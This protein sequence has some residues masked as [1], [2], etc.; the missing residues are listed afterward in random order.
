MLATFHHATVHDGLV[1]RNHGDERGNGVFATRPLPEGTLIFSEYP[2]LGMQLGTNREAGVAVCERCFRFTGPLEAQFEGLLRGL[3][4]P[5]DLLPPQ[6]PAVGPLEEI[7]RSLPAPVP[8]PGGCALRFCSAACAGANFAE[9]HRL[10][11]CGPAA[12]SGGG[13]SSS[14][15]GSSGAGPS[16]S[17]KRGRPAAASDRA[18][19]R[20]LNPRIAP[21]IDELVAEK[22]RVRADEEEEEEEEEENAGGGGGGGGGGGPGGAA[23]GA[24]SRLARVEA[25]LRFESHARE[26][27]EVFVLAARACA[28][29]IVRMRAGESFE[30]AMAPFVAPAWW[31]AVAVPEGEDEASFRKMLRE[32]ITESW[33]LLAP[34][35]APHAPAG[36]A[37]FDDVTSYARI[38]GAFERRNCS[39]Q[40]ASPVEAY[41][42]GVDGLDEGDEK[43]AVQ[44]VTAPLL[45]ELDSAYDTPCEGVGLFPFQATLNHSCEPSVTLL[46]Q[47]DDEER[48]GRVVARLTRD[49]CEGEELCNAYVDV[50]L[51]FAQRRRELAE[52]GFECRCGKCVREAAAGEGGEGGEGSAAGGSSGNA[53]GKARLGWGP[54][55]PQCYRCDK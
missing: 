32:L 26:T 17:A 53:A 12:G 31:D 46:K 8:C 9:H 2:I 23:A 18:V 39:L 3:G 41:F 48:D 24:A 34:A 21:P 14:G 19:A 37:L 10:L 35:L 27:N 45:D 47:L 51:P 38:V 5:L 54:P 52:Y 16:G 15:E 4:A 36:C 29:V 25:L 11:C 7:V 20:A 28:L 43:R 42:L 13:E 55:D 33:R 30:R 44:S 49:V 6:L 22:M 40:V 1:I 50:E